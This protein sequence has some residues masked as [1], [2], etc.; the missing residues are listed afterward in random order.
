MN[1]PLLSYADL[2]L[3]SLLILLVAGLSLLLELGMARRLVVAALRMALQLT[4][5]GLVLT[6]LFA[7]VSPWWTG[8]AALIMILFAGQEVAARQERPLAGLWAYGLG[9]AVMLFSASLVTLFALS[10]QVKPD[11][12]YD[13]RYAV[14]LLGMILGNTMNGIGLGLNSLTTALAREKAAVE[15]RLALGHTRAQAFSGPVRA[16]LATGLMPIVNAMSATGIVSLPGMM[17]GQIL[18]GADPAEAVKYQ[19]LIM[20]LIAGGTGLGATGAVL[21]AALRLS[22]ERQRLRLDRLA[23]KREKSRAV[24]G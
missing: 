4:L 11:P 22:D 9:T 21:G 13:P 23:P 14:P 20:F 7:L 19:I 17:T 6:A 3:A 10:T 1:P 2:T 16:A 12:W 18:A 5:V 24:K 8:L 15:A